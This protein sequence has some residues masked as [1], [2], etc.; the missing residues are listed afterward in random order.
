MNYT[1]VSDGV[2]CEYDNFSSG[3][4]ARL[5]IASC[6]AFRD[7]MYIRN[8]F[9]SNI[10]VLDEFIDSAIDGL[11]IESILE[12]L[13]D[14]S[15]LWKQNIFCISHR[16]EMSNDVFDHVIQLVKTNNISKIEYLE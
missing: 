14:F 5:M 9:S 6:F 1:F 12:I 16:T 13:K 8:S 2:E 15:V 11:A 10:L 3:E 4:K 7:F